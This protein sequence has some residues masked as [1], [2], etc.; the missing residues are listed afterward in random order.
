MLTQLTIR[1]YKCFDDISLETRPIT[2]FCGRNAAGKSTAV[3]VLLLLR[4]VACLPI[5]TGLPIAPND[6]VRLNA[7]FLLELGAVGDVLKHDAGE[8]FIEFAARESDVGDFSVRFDIASSRMEDHFLTIRSCS[9]TFPACLLSQDRGMFTYLCAER[10]GPRDTQSFQ[11]TPRDRLM[12]GIQGEY[13]AEVLMRCERDTVREELR[14]PSDE[15][16]DKASW[17]LT[18]QLELWMREVAPRIEIRTQHLLETNMVSL[19]VKMGGPEAEWLRPANMGFGI[20]HSLPIFLAGLIA[21]PQ[22]LLIID[23][24]ES[25]LHPAGQS[26]LA[27]F[28]G[29][30]AASGVQVVIETH[31]D[32][33][34]NGIRLACVDRHPLTPESVMIYNFDKDDTGNVRPVPIEVTEKGGLTSWPTGFFD[35][36][37]QD[38]AAILKARRSNG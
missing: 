37:E 6:F 8:D 19:R 28:L 27:K 13:V 17:Q 32:H 20:S 34:I 7:P 30:V 16:K 29:R 5:N 21:P 24:P 35:Q 9:P 1:N 38:L 25:H 2:L 10:L 31:S 23:S 36:T 12:I 18:K 14:Y 33:I 11:G 3:Q 26:A 4:E 22:G 15:S